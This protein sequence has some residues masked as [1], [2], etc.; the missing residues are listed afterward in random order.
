M[1]SDTPAQ[2]IAL[3][4]GANRGLGL[5]IARQLAQA[6]VHTLLGARRPE[7]GRAAAAELSAQGLNAAFIHLDVSDPT[8]IAAAAAKIADSHGK[9]DILVNNA[10]SVASDE[11]PPSSSAVEA[12]RTD[13]ETNFFG[14]VA[15]T[16][17]MLPLMALGELRRIVNVSS[18]GGSLSLSADAG[19]AAQLSSRLGYAASKAA[20]NMFSILLGAEL[21]N[22]NFSVRVVTPG[23]VRTD[24]FDRVN[25][26]SA[27]RIRTPSEGAEIIVRCA[28]SPGDDCSGTFISADGD[29]PW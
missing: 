15:V 10:G 11:L 12:M 8:A 3:V 6:G 20:Q 19:A 13:F 22:Q 26:V 23:L 28:L 7:A 17:A 2:P 14:V 5:E 29:V 24:L 16:Q 21:R 25:K 4:T 27:R 1:M 18:R 9:L